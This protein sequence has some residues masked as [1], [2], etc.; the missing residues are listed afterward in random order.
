[1][2]KGKHVEKYQEL[3]TV[4]NKNGDDDGE[5]DPAGVMPCMGQG[6]G[7]GL[8][9]QQSCHVKQV[10]SSFC[11]SF[12]FCRSEDNNNNNSN[13]SKNNNKYFASFCLRHKIPGP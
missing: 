6:P 7:S 8:S 1:M 9:L 13:N 11:V 4:R 5:D 12:R 3:L 2:E 10:L